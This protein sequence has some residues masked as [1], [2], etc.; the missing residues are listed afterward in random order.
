MATD[1]TKYI[2][3]NTTSISNLQ[4]A[5]DMSLND[6]FLIQPQDF[7]TKAKI[8]PL[9]NMVVTLDNC[10][11]ADIINKH[12]NDINSLSSF[13]YNSNNTYF[14]PNVIN[15]NNI[16]DKAITTKKLADS[17]VTTNQIQDGTILWDDLASSTQNTILSAKVGDNPNFNISG[18]LNNDMTDIAYNAFSKIAIPDYTKEPLWFTGGDIHDHRFDVYGTKELKDSKIKF[19]KTP[20]KLYEILDR[21]Y[22]RTTDGDNSWWTNHVKTHIINL[23]YK[24]VSDNDDACVPGILHIFGVVGNGIIKCTINNTIFYVTH[25]ATHTG[26]IIKHGYSNGQL[27]I[28]YLLSKEMVE[29]T[30]ITFTNIDSSGTCLYIHFTPYTQLRSTNE[31]N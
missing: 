8:L 14:K 15:E 10:T 17:C 4:Q 7:N 1:N 22:N 13:I 2:N 29:A 11:F 9:K 30:E 31:T 12:S 24:G 6:Y 27:C 3:Y 23:G 28:P 20:R 25:D 21:A 5:E 26:D 19:F 16:K 18:K